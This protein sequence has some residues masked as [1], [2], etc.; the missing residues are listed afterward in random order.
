MGAVGSGVS[1]NRTVSALCHRLDGRTN[2]G[3][4][5]SNNDD[6][7]AAAAGFRVRQRVRDERRAA[8]IHERLRHTSFRAAE[9][10]AEARREND[11]LLRG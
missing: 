1:T 6:G 4:F 3:A 11:S 10:R 5:V 2:P 9:S 7:F 8:D